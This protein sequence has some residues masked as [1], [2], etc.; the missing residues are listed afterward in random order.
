M[1]LITFETDN[2]TK[3]D[4]LLVYG[5]VLSCSALVGR[6]ISP[7]YRYTLSGKCAVQGEDNGA[8][9]LVRFYW[10]GRKG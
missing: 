10:K 8:I 3:G 9:H 4:P 5:V 2:E 6:Q 7:R 1:F